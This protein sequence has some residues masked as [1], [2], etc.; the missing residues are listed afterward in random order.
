MITAPLRTVYLHVGTPKTGTT[1]LQEFLRL[2]RAAL[3]RD[4]VRYP[5]ERPDLHWHAA[6]EL[7]GMSFAGR[8]IPEAGS[9]W[10]ELVDRVHA[11]DPAGDA[12]TVI[13]HEM[14]G[15][16]SVEQARTAVRDLAPAD[17]HVVV[18]ARD[19]ASLLPAYW[20]EEIKNQSGEPWPHFLARINPASGGE[21]DIVWHLLGL[22]GILRRWG[23][24][25]P[26]ER[27]HLVTV[28]P[29]GSPPGR[30]L[31]RFGSVVGFDAERYGNL[32]PPGNPSMGFVE[33]ELLRRMNAVTRQ[34]LSW[35]DYHAFVKHH[36]V[37]TMLANRSER[38][39]IEL[40]AGDFDWIAE[41][42]ERTVAAVRKSGCSVAGD[43]SELIPSRPDD[44]G[45]DYQT[46]S[47]QSMLDA[48]VDLSV[49]LIAELARAR[50]T[51]PPPTLPPTLSRRIRAVPARLRRAL[52]ARLPL[53]GRS[54]RS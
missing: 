40:T 45:T 20:Q 36:A 14:F 42:T 7:T 30:L 54:A 25:V 10:G 26:A 15:A 12:V 33:A 48:S 4:G 38:I 16:A 1:F 5:G 51:R 18:T 28:P 34:R 22:R 32:P 47:A 31:Q 13:S 27:L 53:K 49:N 3:A 24:A 17:V 35:N 44:L 6:L 11:T 39:P 50:K 29:P 19:L 43:L 8:D 41:E 2:H 9:A 21:D 46:A 52:A 37:P 23:S